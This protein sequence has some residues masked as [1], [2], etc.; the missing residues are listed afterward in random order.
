MPETTT[1]ENP[2]V[3]VHP[4]EGLKLPPPPEFRNQKPKL[5]KKNPL[6]T[7]MTWIVVLALLGVGAYFLRQRL[8][9]SSTASAK[10]DGQQ[11]GPVQVVVASARRGELSVHLAG[12][13]SVAPLN[14]VTVKS[15]VDGQ[16]NTVG[17]T[18]GQLVKKGEV[19]A[20][21]DPRPFQVM[22][23]QAEAQ[24]ARDMAQYNNAKVDQARYQTLVKQGVVPEQ[25]LA[26]QE[27]LV[28]QFNSTLQAD[29]A[30]IDN[31]KLQ[32]S[33]CKILSPLDG[34]V[35]LRQVDPGNMVH[36]TNSTGLVII[37]QLQPIAVLFPIPE[38]S[39]SEVMRRL[40][41]GE[42]MPVEAYDRSGEK[43]VASGRLLTV[44]NEIDQSTGTIRLKAVFD[45]K[46]NTL[47]P[48]QFVNVRLLV[49]IK[50]DKVLVPSVAIQRG[51]SGTFVYVVKDDQTA[52]VVK[53]D[54]GVTEGNETA[55][56][57]GLNGTESVVVDGIDKLRTGS[58][59][60]ISNGA[61]GK[62][63]GKD[64]SADTGKGAGKDGDKG[65]GGGSGSGDKPHS[66]KA[67]K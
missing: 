57:K 56:E 17:F 55:I 12:L 25:Q 51:P 59:V 58:K 50:Q 11:T 2:T 36:A 29:Q 23:A 45:N 46:D 10:P 19:L 61:K 67:G 22:V 53:V 38:D 8:Q 40:R 3:E 1:L 6:V 14:T 28:E 41:T 5:K 18:E 39:L 62:G 31:A 43:K 60:Q 4:T 13:G 9:A 26:T 34:R 54:T 35:G 24:K 63:S 52:E 49:D 37:T 27:A 20:E 64:S 66:K 21:I 33:F 15:R 47:F 30:N 16:L 44:D 42:K 65:S 48:N 32:L 7:A